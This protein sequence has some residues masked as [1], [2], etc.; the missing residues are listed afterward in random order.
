MAAA[1]SHFS[2]W[3]TFKLSL[4]NLLEVRAP[5][6]TTWKKRGGGIH[7][8]GIWVKG[9]DGKLKMLE[10]L[11]IEEVQRGGWDGGQYS[12]AETPEEMG[13]IVELLENYNQKD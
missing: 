5:G 2:V 13:I 9:M 1:N 6:M 3:K 11:N 8:I 4:F 12:Y 7:H 10:S